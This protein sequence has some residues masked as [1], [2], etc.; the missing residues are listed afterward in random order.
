MTTE[1]CLLNTNRNPSLSK[2]QVEDILARYTGCRRVLWLGSG[3]SDEETDGHVD[4]IACF[5]APGRVIIE[6]RL[7]N[8]ILTMLPLRKQNAGLRTRAMRKGGRSK[9]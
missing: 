9:L 5:A 4:N 6:F 8:P 7:S 1:Q 3:F 2:E